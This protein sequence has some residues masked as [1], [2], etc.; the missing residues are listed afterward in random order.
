[1]TKPGLGLEAGRP[2][3]KGDFCRS[4]FATFLPLVATKLMDVC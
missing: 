2:R 4:F 1:M 3:K